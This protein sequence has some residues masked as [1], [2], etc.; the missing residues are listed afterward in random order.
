MKNENFTLIKGDI[1][2]LADVK[3]AV[4]NV[5]VVFHLA[6]IVNVQLSVKNPE[7]TRKVNVDGTLDVLEASLAE[8]VD[9]F[10][11]L[12]TCA[13]YG[14]AQYLPI[15][16]EHPIMPLSSYGASKFEAENL[17]R[18][19][20]YTYGFKTCCLRL[21]NVYGPRQGGGPYAGV[22]RSFID[23]LKRSRPFIIY[24][25]GNQIRDFIHVGDVVDACLAVMEK[26]PKTYEAFNIGTGKPTSINEL[27]NTLMKISS[28]Y[29]KLI[30][31]S[32]RKGD[33]QNSYADIGKA[34]KILG[35]KPKIELEDGLKDLIM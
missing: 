4:K 22:I 34:R 14:E 6:A 9:R 32:S 7:L 13:V 3:K 23:N 12:S 16:E 29:V 20:S 31:K 33:I 28:K 8:N 10:I 2:N 35:F 15:D 1:I 19:Y 24:G 17:C 27:A 18:D 21:F 25:D 26:R 30:Y 11:Y 5:S